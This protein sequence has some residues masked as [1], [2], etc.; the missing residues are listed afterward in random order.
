MTRIRRVRPGDRAELAAML[1]RCTEQTRYHRFHGV[2]QAFPARYLDSALAGDPAHFALVAR[3]GGVIVALASCVTQ[4]DGTAE[5]GILVQDGNQR[6]GLGSRL[7]GLLVE[8]ADSAG[9]QV[10]Q[11]SVLA[12][13]PWILRLL[14]TYG[15]CETE[16]S[17]GVVDV[18][19]YRKDT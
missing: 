11:A 2:V 12:D 7:L 6:C 4:P 13:Q 17:H 1:Q 10:L 15:S 18:I 8:H 16:L 9:Q 14:S 19:L 5:L 3:S